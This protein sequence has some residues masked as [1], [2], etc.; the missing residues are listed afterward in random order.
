MQHLHLAALFNLNLTLTLT[1]YKTYNQWYFFLHW[2]GFLANFG[3]PAVII[4]VLLADKVKYDDFVL[5]VH[6][7]LACGLFTKISIF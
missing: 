6:L 1:K 2:E 7:H 5:R 4:P 3:L